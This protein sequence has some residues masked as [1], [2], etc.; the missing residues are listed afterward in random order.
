MLQVCLYFSFSPRNFRT[1]LN[2]VVH[3]IA[4]YHISLVTIYITNTGMY[5]NG[6][7]THYTASQSNNIDSLECQECNTRPLCLSFQTSLDSACPPSLVRPILATKSTRSISAQQLHTAPE[8]RST[9]P[10]PNHHFTVHVGYQASMVLLNI[11]VEALTTSSVI[12]PPRDKVPDNFW[13]NWS[14][15]LYPY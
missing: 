12:C 11:N 9:L 14:Q 3:S 2:A 1:E 8:H 13:C 6:R 15:E 10:P 4:R 5:V 7:W